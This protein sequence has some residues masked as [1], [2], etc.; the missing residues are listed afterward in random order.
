[1]T[2]SPGVRDSRAALVVSALARTVLGAL[3]VLVLVSVVPA[4]AGWQSTVVMSGSMA[5]GVQPGDL[6]LVRPVDAADLTPGD[7]L[8][9]DDP[10]VAGGLRLHRLVAVTDGGLLQLKGDANATPDG[11]LVDPAA[12]HGVGALRLPDLGLP[13]LWASQGRWLPVSG[14]VLALA[15]LLGLA[16]LHRG[17]DD[18]PD[19]P[20]T[21]APADT[22]GRRP[23]RHL[24]TVVRGTTAALAVAALV[25]TT[26]VAV[27]SGSTA[28]HANTFS[29]APYFTCAAAATGETAAQYLPLQE[30]G[31]TVAA[32]LGSYSGNGT[33]VGSVSFVTDGPAC[34]SGSRAVTL[35][36]ATAFVRTPIRVDN[37]QTFSTQLW[38][39]TATAGGRGGY[40]I[41]F[42]NGTDGD[43]STAKD[44]L[45]Y[46]TD[47]GKLKF[48]VYNGT[49]LTVTSPNSYN[50]ARWHLVTATFSPSTGARL[51]VDGARVA[52]NAGFTAAEQGSGLF[53]AGY[54]SLSG[55]PDAP[56]SYYFAGSI[57]HMGVYASAL[58]DAE[59]ADQYTAAG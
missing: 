37:P 15:A 30:T 54:D 39:R 25:P 45:V 58:T 46:L 22:D 4:V 9:V 41:G 50:D 56:A 6:T 16:L 14:A 7:V 47:A 51:Y 23:R 12:V 11:S 5:P 29:A 53:R 59:V 1:V 21:G 55:W 31:G 13:V 33:Y 19:E 24:R 48:G 8:L 35:D 42:G 49:P 32:N 17:P 36:G 3:V 26:A 28:N 38:F 34:T 18:E 20:T 52:A 40:L 10:D 57:A 43:T 44:R 27:F 2:P